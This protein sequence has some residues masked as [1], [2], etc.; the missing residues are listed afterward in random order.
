M[1]KISRDEL[2]KRGFKRFLMS[3]KNSFDGYAY[4]STNRF[5]SLNDPF[6]YLTADVTKLYFAP[7]NYT[8]LR[9][10][11]AICVLYYTKTTD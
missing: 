4:A 11:D 9:N 1:N 7:Y 5:H 6:N 8:A 10:C 3:W 2:K